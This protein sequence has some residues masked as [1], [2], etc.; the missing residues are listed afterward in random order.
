VSATNAPIY[1][2]AAAITVFVTLAA[3]MLP[4]MRATRVDP[5]EAFRE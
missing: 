3:T 2:A 4:A 1:G 5:T